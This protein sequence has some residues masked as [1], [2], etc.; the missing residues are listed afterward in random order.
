MMLTIVLVLTL[1]EK[2]SRRKRRFHAL[3]RS[4]RPV[5]RLRLTGLRAWAA[6][7]LCLIP[8]IA[9]FVLPV[10][11]ILSVAAL[12][13]WNTSALWR[14]A[15]HTVLLGALA[16]VIA[17]TAAIFLTQA[18]R[19]STRPWIARLVPITTIGYAAPGA[20][21]AIGI[22]IP[23]A[24]FDHLL[25]D[26]IEAVSGTDP[27][28]LLTGSAVAIVLCLSMYMFPAAHPPPKP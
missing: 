28:L 16:A 9:G 4:Q 11:V 1:V 17:V 27:G 8:V 7:V 22:L 2:I 6:T 14:A 26:V 10:G 15:G 21:L 18:V 24:L 3:G 25:A 5:Q 19:Y 13:D 20:V 12:Q 23:F